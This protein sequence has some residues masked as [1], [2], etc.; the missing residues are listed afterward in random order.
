MDN[1]NQGLDT[2]NSITND[3]TA[4]VTTQIE[5]TITKL[6]TTIDALHQNFTD[7]KYLILELAKKLYETG[8][9]Q[10]D[11]ICRKIKDLLRDKIKESKITAKWIEEC[12]P[13][14]YK[15]KYTKSELSS[16]SR[17]KERLKE[18]VVHN[19]GKDF[20]EPSSFNGQNINKDSHSH[21]ARVT[22]TNQI[23]EKEITTKLNNDVI[24]NR[25]QELEETLSCASKLPSA[26]FLSTTEIR[27]KIP[28]EKYY[29]VKTTMNI[30]NKYCTLIFDTITGIL[31]R[32]ESDQLNLK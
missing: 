14:E 24:C 32:S 6:R 26:A 30:S 28:R 1:N 13:D 31:L 9:F 7:T 5:M 12:L 22:D 10:Q 23:L 19:N 21:L 15:R 16:L 29:D 17:N 27:F 25:N 4:P 3:T 11:K 20:P 2:H 18:I 8:Q